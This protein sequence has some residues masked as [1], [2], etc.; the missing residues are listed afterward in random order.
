MENHKRPI[1]FNRDRVKKD[2]IIKN[3]SLDDYVGKWA[4]FS[5]NNGI[6]VAGFVKDNDAARL[7]LKPY[8]EITADSEGKAYYFMKKEGHCS[9]RKD[10]IGYHSRSSREDIENYTE[11]LNTLLDSQFIKQEQQ[12]IEYLNTLNQQKDNQIIIVQETFDMDNLRED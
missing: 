4:Y 12:K 1:G 9:L 6:N 7:H 10:I 3:K 2:Q 11:Y 8:R 5:L